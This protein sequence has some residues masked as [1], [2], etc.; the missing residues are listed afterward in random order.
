M[1]ARLVRRV[2]LATGLSRDEAQ[3]AVDRV[4]FIMRRAVQDGKTL[5]FRGFGTFTPA[6]WRGRSIPNQKRQAWFHVPDRQTVRFRA[7][8]ELT[9]M[10]EGLRSE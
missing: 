3:D 6:V 8:P 10:L 7:A 5:R 1:M 9:A 2:A 4:W